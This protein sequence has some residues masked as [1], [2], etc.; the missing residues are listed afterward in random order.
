MSIATNSFIEERARILAM[1]Q[2]SSRRDLQVI[3]GF[4]G[5]E[6]FDLMVRLLSGAERGQRYFGVKLKGTTEVLSS[7][8]DAT[9]YLNS[10]DDK[11]T[12]LPPSKSGFPL[13][14]AV[15]S[16]QN[17]RG[18]YSWR[19]EPV[20]DEEHLP[21]VKIHNDFVCRPFGRAA[22]GQ[23]VETVN[24]WYDKFFAMLVAV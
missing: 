5:H 19:I 9:R 24:H 1:V 14:L 23:I 2:L 12:K 22:L 18:F 11:D 4:P 15:F 10:I 16:M 20:I 13:I 17:D 21:R 7:A 3:G 8:K 6:E